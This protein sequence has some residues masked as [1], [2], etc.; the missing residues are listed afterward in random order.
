[1]SALRL[2]DGEGV[3]ATARQVVSDVA[4][5]VAL[6]PFAETDDPRRAER[7]LGDFAFRW[8]LATLQKMG[9]L[10]EPGEVYA[11]DGLEQRL[12]ISPRYHR[13]FAALIRR[14]EE[15]GLVTVGPDG[16]ATTALVAGYALDAVAEQVAVFKAGFRNDYPAA[17]GLLDFM[18]CCLDRFEEIVT[19]RIDVT[20][21]LFSGGNMDVFGAA[22]GGDAVADYFNHI[23]AAA[24]E[25]A[26]VRSG[27]TAKIRIVEIG[28][29]TGGTTAAV[30][31]AI[32]RF[33]DTVEYT[34]TD[35]SMSF[36]RA[37]RRRFGEPYPWLGYRTLNI[38]EDLARQGFDAEGFDVV[39]AANVLHD[40]R[41]IER[42][43]EQ[44][45][46]LL[47]PGGLLVLNEFTAVKDCLFFSGALLHG[48][49]LF[50]DPSRRLR[51]S[52]LLSVPLWSR[53]L[54]Q[55]GFSLAEA[56]ALPTQTAGFECSQAVMLCAA[57]ASGEA[58]E[59]GG[60]AQKSRLIGQWL[61]QDILTLLGEERSAAYSARRPLMEMGLDSIEL[62]ELKA[63][64]RQRFDVQLSPAF[65]FE[66]ETQEK[67]AKALAAAVSPEQLRAL[68]A[69]ET[70]GRP[71]H[72]GS[73]EGEAGGGRHE[74]HE[75][76]IAI[77]GMACRFPGGATSP[78]AF[79]KLLERGGDAV[80]SMPSGRWQ[81]PAF[82]DVA[83]KHR[84]IDR[85]GFLERIDE[86]DARF[87]RTS[88][89]EAELMD[90]QQRLLLELSWEAMEDAGHR[91]SELAGRRVGV[92]VGACQSDYRDVVVAAMDAADGY[93]GS[94]TAYAMLANRLSYFFDFKGPSL[95]VDTACSSSLFAL[96]EAMNALRRGEC[97]QALVGAV[98]LLCS[99]TI[100]LS[101]YQ[102][103]M[104]SPSGQCRTFDATADGYVRGEGGAMLILKPLA[105]A[106]AAGDSVYGLVKGT[107]V[108]HG[109]QASTLTAPKP[110]AQ[111][112]VVEAAWRE[113]GAPADAV[114]YIEAHGTGTRLGDPIEISGLT[115]AFQRLYAAQGKSWPA[116]APVCALGSVK[117]NLGH[118]EAA[119]G[120]AGV[121]KV[122]LSM[123][124]GQIPRTRNF[125]HLNPDIDLAATP[126]HIAERSQVWLSCRDAQ[127]RELPR[128][129]G[130][131]SFGF[132]GANAHAVLEQHPGSGS[133]VAAEKG[134][135]LIPLSARTPEELIR[136]AEKLLEFIT[137]LERE[138][139][140]GAPSGA[141]P[142]RILDALRDVL[143]RRGGVGD[144]VP[145]DL[146]WAELGWGAVE[147]RLFLAAAEEALGVRLHSRS[148]IES[149]TLQSLAER[150]ARD[151]GETA[152]AGKAGPASTAGPGLRD[153]AYTLQAGREA[154]AERVAIVARDWAE[155][156][157]ALRSYIAGEQSCESC[158]RGYSTA[159]Q[160]GDE[161]KAG[162]ALAR[163]D[164]PRLAS[165]WV[166]GVEMDWALL[167][168][169]SR[170][171]RVRLPT[172]PFAR[173]RH[174]VS[175]TK[176]RAR[177]PVAHPLLSQ[178]GS[179]VLEYRFGTELTGDEPFLASHVIQGRRMLPA[180][181]YLE[182]VQ[183]AVE[184]A[185]GASGRACLEGVVWIEP[186]CVDQ[187]P[188]Q[189]ALRLTAES[190]G[191]SFEISSRSDDTAGEAVFHSQGRARIV[192]AATAPP[193]LD[194]AGLRA[195][196]T[197]ARFSAAEC[198]RA[199]AA[200]GYEYGPAQRGIEALWVG[201][202]EIVAQ[203]TLPAFLEA[204][205]KD[206]VLHPAM[207]DSAIQA[208]IGF[209]LAAGLDTA[210]PPLP[211]ELES[212]MVFGA[213]TVRM[214][215]VI[216]RRQEGGSAALTFDIDLCEESGRLS[217]RFTGWTL[218]PQKAA[219]GPG[220]R[221]GEVI[222]T[223]VWD[224]EPIRLQDAGVIAA[225]GGVAIVGGTEAQLA[226]IREHFPAVRPLSLEPA[227]SLEQMGEKIA[228]WGDVGHV[229]W[230]VPPHLPE[231]MGDESILTAQDAGLRFGFRL[232]KALL[233]QGYGDRSLAWTVI[234]T[235]AQGVRAGDLA[236]PTH[237]GVHGLAGTLAKELAQWSVRLLD[238]PFAGR[239]PWPDLLAVAGDP[240]G[241]AWAY[242]DGRWYRQQLV[243]YRPAAE[244]LPVYR[245]GGV[246]I[247]IGGAGGIGE[248]WSEAL[249][250]RLRVQLVWIGRRPLDEALQARLDRLSRLGPA[251]LY[252]A[253]DAT[254]RE[255]LESARDTVKRELGRID[256]VIHAAVVL[257]D[258][259]LANM[260]EEEL[261]AGL[262]PKIDVCVR[263][264]QVFAGE[265]LDFVLFFSSMLAFLKWPGQSNY[266][267]GC[268]FKDA[269]AERLAAEW[270][271]RVRTIN[272][273]YWGT[274]GV[275]ASDFHR[276]LMARKG[277]GSIELDGAMQVL[278]Q[279]LSGPARQL[280]HVNTIDSRAL[281]GFSVRSDEWATHY[282][283]ALPSWIEGVR[284]APLAESAEERERLPGW[285]LAGE[286][287]D[288]AMTELLWAQLQ[289]LPLLMRQGQSA[290][291]MRARVG[292]LDRLA[293]WLE[294]SLE[295]LESCGYA[296]RSGQLV[297]AAGAAP[298]D[299]EAAWRSWERRKGEWLREADWRAHL[300][301]A[302]AALRAL[303]EILVGRCLAAEVLFAGLY[304]DSRPP[305][306][307]EVLRRG[308]VPSFYN[309]TLAATVARYVE[310]RRCWDPE[311]RI[312]ILEVGAGTGA[313]S[314]PVFAALNTY[315][316]SVEEYAFTDASQ[317]FIAVARRAPHR[318]AYLTH[319]VFDAEIPAAE[320]G[321]AHDRYDL[322]IA[323][324]VVNTARDVARTLRNIKTVL[325]ANG[326]ILL[327]ELAANSWFNHLTFGLLDG[328]W[329][330]SDAE[331]R[332]PGGP[333]LQPESWRVVL[334]QEGFRSVFFPAEPAH[335]YGRQVIVAE[336]D[337]FVRQERVLQ[338][339]SRPREERAAKESGSRQGLL[340]PR[341]DT[342]TAGIAELMAT[343]RAVASERLLAYL[344]FKVAETLGADEASLD[345][346]SRPFADSLLGEFGMDSLSA[347]SLRNTLRR[348]I[349]LDLPVYRII[350]EKV[351]GIVDALYEPL[352]LKHVSE[353][354]RPADEE[355]ETFVF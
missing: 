218:R 175:E 102:A 65:L 325:K 188:V 39:V 277:F 289:S 258:K 264:A 118:L 211:F 11:P 339:S 174:W 121:I 233:A 216:R 72:P 119:A 176:L 140:A 103:G 300:E 343:P 110:E 1:M 239:W 321:I 79:W 24:V 86:F 44:A 48:Y 109:G 97:E 350:G 120:L 280:F 84:G 323:T 214:W 352:L 263:L 213:C 203:L 331:L 297:R 181:A 144:E 252:I 179:G 99:P 172:Y 340:V 142:A 185:L 215:A 246:Y 329:R 226:A 58:V 136:R 63:L 348:E 271:C 85:G 187:S 23:V 335:C 266:I 117:S 55:T 207:A 14:L 32:E 163:R 268:V 250:R 184:R 20:D 354:T 274:V 338:P 57:P 196:C 326:L 126:F 133:G 333:A 78:E 279:L 307:G 267:A 314:E 170:P 83:E 257:R 351:F 135:F 42:A 4:A 232:I 49:W 138:P 12:G 345:S 61:E 202:D 112:D 284:Q 147:T 95:T 166:R 27:R 316:A 194:L 137:G 66:H 237:A 315:E 282:Q 251:P 349:G 141:S 318:P 294:R 317:A 47:K 302:E 269:F 161:R 341:L 204:A 210:R 76:S 217:T 288:G 167:Y 18:A 241:N 62:V 242:R 73:G 50:E 281:E 308:A 127:G 201:E 37:A 152:P 151:H 301:F 183:A 5:K 180:V 220:L 81:W 54:E 324:N 10:R 34:F 342:T 248:A 122:L 182:M 199:W 260:T 28:A 43:L 298:A 25:S 115:A 313:T 262:A 129:A 108:N 238:L 8:V 94:G 82:V 157:S 52:C 327:N 98:N 245:P 171:R 197:R 17:A 225:A 36:L 191:L 330:F 64:V 249:L 278:D 104:L 296:E 243:P 222:L 310:E 227:D 59:G 154:M 80:V 337:G 265:P 273:G 124:H 131:S 100:S 254:D 200:M 88:P 231:S 283:T 256:G 162:A 29:G 107:A 56:F 51:D 286:E 156:A 113:A 209:A 189:V 128:R 255:Q 344:R 6:F 235:G 291:E 168:P 328:W 38:E 146:E 60:D 145:P 68:R 21:V 205:R 77:V 270:P 228:S 3:P 40:T 143:R 114:G 247:V 2:A 346:R 148:L 253:A 53:A 7:E 178:S 31:A 292:I 322:V 71:S 153:V 22:F 26:I 305:V 261:A 106:L 332:I 164:L 306:A 319:D 169:A 236:S 223:P 212:A 221:P 9:A 16:L 74:S 165:L 92:F 198:Y 19:G 295:R 30:L 111:A 299:P 149:P 275:A 173:E 41:D 240:H 134:D 190:E 311:C 75:S 159:L 87:F 224:A 244:T 67:M 158:H 46:K 272:W 285:S 90:P 15:V 206:F 234:T 13:H 160:A 125:Q 89:K 150:I 355:T 132:G 229:V 320:Q 177:Q 186:L 219:A 69:G 303:P 70:E 293:P 336:S 192:P 155:L 35:V 230:I 347:N 93:V 208:T 123:E 91:P 259:S 96:H 276:S 33:S 353:E 116:P 290:A 304:D 130:V 45:R 139:V 105:A 309:Q 193:S 195:R 312:R 101:Y 334:E 287:I